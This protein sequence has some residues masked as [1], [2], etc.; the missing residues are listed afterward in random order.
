MSRFIGIDELIAE[1]LPCFSKGH[2][3]NLCSRKEIPHIKKGGRVSFEVEEV[4]RWMREDTSEVTVT[5]FNA[6]PPWER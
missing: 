2:I 5:D 6:T 3:R 1:V 4:V